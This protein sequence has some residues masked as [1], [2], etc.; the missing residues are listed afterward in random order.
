MSRSNPSDDRAAAL[1]RAWDTRAKSPLCRFFVASHQGWSSAE[2]WDRQ[3]VQDLRT[4]FAGVA[5]NELRQMHVLEI[6]CGVG[7]LGVKLAPLA[8]SY[9]GFD[10]APAM[11]AEARS[12]LSRF[13]NA[14]VAGSHDGLVPSEVEDRRY[15]FVFA[16]GVLIHTPLEMAKA[17]VARGCRLLAPQGRARFQLRGDPFEFDAAAEYARV[18]DSLR[19]PG[20]F[21]LPT[22]RSD[23]HVGDH[24]TALREQIDALVAEEGDRV[25][26]LGHQFSVAEARTIVQ[27]NRLKGSVLKLDP[28]FVYLDIQ[29]SAAPE[30]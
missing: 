17:I 26:Y 24:V 7:R 4:L 21:T 10:I 2:E 29:G 25:A 14:R 16:W 19:E 5:A 12:E 27:E 28:H 23:G 3:T 20:P 6:G 8:A 22:S 9:T 1:R 15:D 18:P 30:A 13:G 11:V